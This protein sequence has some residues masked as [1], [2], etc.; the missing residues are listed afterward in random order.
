M[1]V[2]GSE[3]CVT[4]NAKRAAALDHLTEKVTE[5]SEPLFIK[6]PEY[7]KDVTHLDF[8]DVYAV[9]HLFNVIDGSLHHS[10][11]K[12]LLAGVR[13]G[14]KSK[15]QDIQEARDTLNRWLVLNEEKNNDIT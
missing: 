10:S 7:Y 11:K 12:I 2:R 4:C 15:Y 14:N 8:I 1:A 13:N 3:Y 9:H 5:E 6:Y